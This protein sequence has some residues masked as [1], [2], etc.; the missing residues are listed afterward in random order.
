[1]W[2][3]L[4]TQSIRHLHQIHQIESRALA[5]EIL[6]KFDLNM[7]YGPVVGITRL[8]RWQRAQRLN[9]N[10]PPIV[11]QL[12]QQFSHHHQQPMGSSHRSNRSTKRSIKKQTGETLEEEDCLITQN[13]WFNEDIL[14][15]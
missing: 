2:R 5:V 8:Q 4:S 12:I 14:C 7:D 15:K 3:N 1:M 6:R 9:L 11:P 10:P 13:L